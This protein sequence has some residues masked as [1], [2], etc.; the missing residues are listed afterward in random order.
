MHWSPKA[1]YHDR[2]RLLQLSNL[3]LAEGPSLP[4]ELLRKVLVHNSVLANLAINRAV[5][6]A[7]QTQ[8]A[9]VVSVTDMPF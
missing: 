9:Q 5:T 1:G 4:T 8:N 3:H 7:V 6:R 2:V